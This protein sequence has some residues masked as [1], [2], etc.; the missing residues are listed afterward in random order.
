LQSLVYPISC[1]EY[2]RAQIVHFAIVTRLPHDEIADVINE[3]MAK[4]LPKA[5]HSFNSAQGGGFRT[6]LYQVLACCFHDSK[7]S[8]YRRQRRER[9]LSD[10]I[11]RIDRVPEQKLPHGRRPVRKQADPKDP[12]ASN[13][14]MERVRVVVQSMGPDVLELFEQWATG[15]STTLIAEGIWDAPPPRYDAACNGYGPV[16]VPVWTGTRMPEVGTVG[17]DNDRRRAA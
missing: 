2:V 3:A 15:A 17:D 9:A 12:L 14:L 5:V 7:R 16:C 8:Q 10:L 1:Y 13:E 11:E 4:W 6:L